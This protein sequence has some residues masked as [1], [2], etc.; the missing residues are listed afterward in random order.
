[1]LQ[2]RHNA[3]SIA[4]CCTKHSDR[5]QQTQQEPCVRCVHR[6]YHI[7]AWAG[8]AHCALPMSKGAA[9]PDGIT[10]VSS[11]RAS[12]TNA[13]VRSGCL[14]SSCSRLEGALR[15]AQSAIDAFVG[16][17]IAGSGWRAHCA[18]PMSSAKAQPPACPAMASGSGSWHWKHGRPL[19]S[20]R[21]APWQN[22][23]PCRTS[24]RY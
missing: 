4:F 24:G 5:P 20:K 19:N 7:H 17:L 15:V 23:M 21:H 16:E 11:Y 14:I 13:Y 2:T 3:S 18:L 1:M 10:A 6:L 22:S 9:F 12:Y 8:E